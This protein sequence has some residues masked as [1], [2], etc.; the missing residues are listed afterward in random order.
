MW[1]LKGNG[2]GSSSC[3]LPLQLTSGTVL[4]P[5]VSAHPHHL[6]RSRETHLDLVDIKCV[7]VMRILLR[8][9]SA[10]LGFFRDLAH[11]RKWNNNY[12]NVSWSKTYPR[13]LTERR[14]AYFGFGLVLGF[15][16]FCP[17]LLVCCFGS[18]LNVMAGACDSGSLPH[19]LKSKER[20]RKPL[21][22]Q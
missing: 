11:T 8:K 2:F 17:W 19:A 12:I 14:N 5:W 16:G 15:K 22:S 6:R 20:Y 3:E 21:G 13:K 10:F 18:V 9:P 7:R 4:K 1:Q